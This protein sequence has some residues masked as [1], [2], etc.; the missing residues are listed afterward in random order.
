MNKVVGGAP[1]GG[2]DS[3]TAVENHVDKLGA[4]RKRRIKSST[5]FSEDTRSLRSGPWSVDWL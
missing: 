4:S 1:L 3:N 2:R 5:N